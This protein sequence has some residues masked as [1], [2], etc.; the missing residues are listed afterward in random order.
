MFIRELVCSII[1]HDWQAMS[2]HDFGR[3]RDQQVRTG[4]LCLRC[5]DAEAR[6]YRGPYPRPR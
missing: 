4:R 3:E 2:M 6:V 5:Y 1:G